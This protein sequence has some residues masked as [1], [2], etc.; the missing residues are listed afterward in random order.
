ME[1]GFV[2][3]DA[4][5]IAQMTR[6]TEV[7]DGF[8]TAYRE[9]TDQK[10]LPQKPGSV[11]SDQILN[12]AT[13][14]L[15]DVVLPDLNKKDRTPEAE[16]AQIPGSTIVLAVYAAAAQQTTRFFGRTARAREMFRD[17]R[18]TRFAT[19]GLKRMG[20]TIAT[21]GLLDRPETQAYVKL[22]RGDLTRT[23]TQ[24]GFDR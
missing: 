18:D 22:V 9:L 11:G 20:A 14:V 24:M 4:A 8:Y 12:R 10:G 6:Q 17:L 5:Y 15:E 1:P 21:P 19:D 7:R 3:L 2:R 13:R 16:V 23:L